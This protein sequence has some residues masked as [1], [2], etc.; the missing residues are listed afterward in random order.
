VTTAG[1]PAEAVSTLVKR[2]EGDPHHFRYVAMKGFS[3]SKD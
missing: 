1:S 3:G 2:V